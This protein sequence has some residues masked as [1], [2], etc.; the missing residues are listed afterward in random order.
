MNISFIFAQ[1]GTK[2]TVEP[3]YSSILK[4]F[5]DANFVVYTDDSN[6]SFPKGVNV[7][8]V[9]PIFEIN[10][11]YGNRC[12]DLFKAIGLLDSED[13]YAI[14]LDNDMRIVSN[15]VKTILPIT[16]RFGLCLPCNPRHLVRVDNSIGADSDNVFDETNGNTYAVNMSPI[17][18]YTSDVDS[19]DILSNYVEEIKTTPIRGPTAMWRAIWKSKSNP[20]LLPPQW[21]VCQEHC[22]IGGEIML[23]VGHEKVRKYYK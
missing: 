18:L 4:Y 14:A 16:K 20:Y 11:R 22:G 9:N 7:K 13:E 10:H 8:L 23:H 19:R 21:C 17:S 15:E 12:N 5:K 2:Q 6:A 1:F 3:S